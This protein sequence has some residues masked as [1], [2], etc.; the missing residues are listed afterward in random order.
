[1]TVI[2]IGTATFITISK[3]VCIQ[4]KARVS[5]NGDTTLLTCVKRIRL[6]MHVT[7][8]AHAV[9]CL[10]IIRRTVT[11]HEKVCIRTPEINAETLHPYTL[12]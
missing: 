7:E 10:L 11:D 12:D 9:M 4:P 2:F 6:F 3:Q 5:V 1:M 8:F